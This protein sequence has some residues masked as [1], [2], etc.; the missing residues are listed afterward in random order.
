M[1]KNSFSFGTVG[2]LFSHAEVT[3]MKS[4]VLSAEGQRSAADLDKRMRETAARLGVSISSRRGYERVM[5]ELG[6]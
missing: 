6:K 1:A 3:A 2:S 4:A 5:R